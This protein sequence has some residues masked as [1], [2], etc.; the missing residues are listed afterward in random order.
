MRCQAHEKTGC[1]EDTGF[2][3]SMREVYG[4]NAYVNALFI[5]GHYPFVTPAVAHSERDTL[6]INNAINKNR[7]KTKQRIVDIS[8][9][10]SPFDINLVFTTV[11]FKWTYHTSFDCRKHHPK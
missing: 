9:L 4:T 6:V 5:G 2:F 3:V 8:F 11:L 7:V 10:S 1:L